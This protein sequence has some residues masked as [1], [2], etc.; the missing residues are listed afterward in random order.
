MMSVVY[1]Y[2]R[3]ICTSLSVFKYYSS[4][5]VCCCIPIL[6]HSPR[7]IPVAERCLLQWRSQRVTKCSSYNIL[8]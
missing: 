6:L 8:V 1:L 7:Y 4:H 2:N 3:P 5:R